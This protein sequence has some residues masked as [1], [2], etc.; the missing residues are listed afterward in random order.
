MLFIMCN[1][2]ICEGKVESRL[3]SRRRELFQPRF[4]VAPSSDLHLPHFLTVAHM[5]EFPLPVFMASTNTDMTSLYT[6]HS[7]VAATSF[8]SLLVGS[9]YTHRGTYKFTNLILNYCRITFIS[10]WSSQRN[11]HEFIFALST[12]VQF[13]LLVGSVTIFAEQLL[14]NQIG[15]YLHCKVQYSKDTQAKFKWMRSDTKGTSVA[16]VYNKPNLFTVS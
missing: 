4:R 2:V 16:V 7:T 12:A 15:V 6:L 5:T 3:Q 13:L 11:T 1:T 8:M 14:C 10:L 9:R